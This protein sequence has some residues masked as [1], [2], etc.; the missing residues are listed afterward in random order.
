VGCRCCFFTTTN[1]LLNSR[2]R[3]GRIRIF[4]IGSQTTVFIFEYGRYS[5]IER[6]WRSSQAEYTIHTYEIIR[7]HTHDALDRPAFLF[8][9]VSQQP[10]PASKPVNTTNKNSNTHPLSSSMSSPTSHP[11]R[12]PLSHSQTLNSFPDSSSHKRNKPRPTGSLLASFLATFTPHTS[13]SLSSSSAS[14]SG[15]PSPRLK[16]H[17]SE[18]EL[19]RD[20]LS[21]EREKEIGEIWEM[22][23]RQSREIHEDKL[24]SFPCISEY[25]YEDQEDEGRR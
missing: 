10:I 21:P 11:R 6:P 4:V 1:L 8:R 2:R 18:V 24:T 16:Q 17:R 7:I 3:I 9:S 22:F 25:E 15:V 23:K 20:Y 19:R 13:P 5:E 12:P 14:A